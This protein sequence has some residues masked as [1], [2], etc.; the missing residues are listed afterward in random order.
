M[1]TKKFAIVR[2]EDVIN[3]C[4]GGS[5][6]FFE[7][8]PDNEGCTIIDISDMNPWPGVNWKYIDGEFIAPETKYEGAGVPEGAFEEED[9]TAPTSV[10]PALGV[11]EGE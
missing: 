6:E 4:L 10:T 2:G 9:T 7:S 1:T 5:I 11:V 8:L 3:S